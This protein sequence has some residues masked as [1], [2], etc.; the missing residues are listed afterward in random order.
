MTQVAYIGL[1]ANLGDRLGALRRARRRLNE[2]SGIEVEAASSL[3]ETAPMGA[4]GAA[5]A[6]A[7][8]DYLNGVVRV[9]TSLGARELLSVL[10]C[11]EREMG[12]ER[13]ESRGPRLIDCDLLLV[14]QDVIFEEGLVVPHPRL[15]GRLFVL[16][17]L[18]EL[19][20]GLRHPVTGLPLAAYRELLGE[21][22]A[23]RPEAERQ[24]VR[25]LEGVRW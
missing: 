16:C 21:R 24:R 2:T 10:L 13:R 5:G 12:R 19:E 8:P 25:R 4:A 1:G 22:Q 11:L 18:L 6:A 15:T 9:C 17:P 14:A 3:Y 23:G 7:Q 20:G